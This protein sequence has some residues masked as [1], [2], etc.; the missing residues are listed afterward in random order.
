MY[1]A[2]CPKILG[3]KLS[4]YKI[5]VMEYENDVSIGKKLGN[6]ILILKNISTH[7]VSSL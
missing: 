5:E 6:T 7:C 3:L 2:C 4:S 1:K